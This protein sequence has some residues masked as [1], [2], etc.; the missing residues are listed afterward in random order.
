MGEVILSNWNLDQPQWRAQ[1][2]DT[3]EDPVRTDIK[4]RLDET[5]GIKPDTLSPSGDALTT[6]Y[7]GWLWNIQALMVLLGERL[8]RPSLI[9]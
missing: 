1:D 6:A 9:S 2:K 7:L 3:E 5:R 8:S 4:D